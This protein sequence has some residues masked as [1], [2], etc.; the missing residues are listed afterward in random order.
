MEGNIMRG[1]VIALDLETTGFDPDADS[2]I[3]V[4]IPLNCGPWNVFRRLFKNDMAS[5]SLTQPFGNGWKPKGWNGSVRKAGFMR[6]R[7]TILSSWKKGEHCNCL[8]DP[9]STH[10][11]HLCR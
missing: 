9:Y 1:E 6:L 5:I 10:P 3:E 4:G 8:S 11:G 7:N 2:I